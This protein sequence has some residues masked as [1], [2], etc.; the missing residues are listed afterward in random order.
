MV[1]EFLVNLE[2][3]IQK[4]LIH[5]QSAGLVACEKQIIVLAG[6]GADSTYN[7]RTRRTF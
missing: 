1:A 7:L 2:E 3:G 6:L 5:S 4:A